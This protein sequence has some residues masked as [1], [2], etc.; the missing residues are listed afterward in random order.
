MLS[1]KAVKTAQAAAIGSVLLLAGAYVFQALGYAPCQMC[2]WQRYPHMV[3]I[4][5]GLSLVVLPHRL[6]VILGALS[7]FGTAIIGGFHSGV[8]QKWWNGPS[9]CTG[10]GSVLNGLSGQD[11]L[12]TDV[13]D[14][15]VMCDEISW[16]IIGLSMPTLNAIFSAILGTVWLLSLRR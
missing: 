11:L 6:V 16:A 5:A 12:A 2:L 15:L 7:A 13:I 9:S 10:N 4:L 14:K 3:A 1:S 8:E